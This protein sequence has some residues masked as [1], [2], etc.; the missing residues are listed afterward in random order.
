MVEGGEAGGV[1]VRWRTVS[2]GNLTMSTPHALERGLFD[3]TFSDLIDEVGKIFLTYGC[4]LVDG[5]FA[6]WF[7]L[8]WGR[9]GES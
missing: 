9:G 8:P 3:D 2:Q 7:S 1:L 6:S 4:D 5:E